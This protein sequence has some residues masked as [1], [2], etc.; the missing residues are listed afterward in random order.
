MNSVM[1]QIRELLARS[2]QMTRRF[3]ATIY[4]DPA[5]FFVF[6]A[7]VFG[8]V[9]IAFVPPFMNPD[10]DMHLER[11]YQI[12][13]GRLSAQNTDGIVGGEL[14]TSFVIAASSVATMKGDTNVKYS[15]R[16]AHLLLSMPLAKHKQELIDTRTAAPYV[17]IVYAPQVVGVFFGRLL[18][19]NPTFLLYIARFCGLIFFIVCGFVAIRLLPMKKWLLTLLLCLPMSLASASSVTA[20]TVIA[21]TLV[22]SLAMI[23]AALKDPLFAKKR[24][25]LPVLLAASFTLALSK[26]TYVL[27]GFLPLLLV[28]NKRRV[29][30]STQKKVVVIVLALTAVCWVGWAVHVQQ[31]NIPGQTNPLAVGSHQMV[32]NIE[33][34]P[35]QFA[36][37]AGNSLVTFNA[38]YLFIEFVGMFGWEDTPLPIWMVIAFFT[39][40]T[41]FALQKEHVSFQLARRT[42]L[43]VAAAAVLTTAIVVSVVYVK[44]TLPVET[45]VDGLQG[46]YFWPIAVSLIVVLP[47]GYITFKTKGF[48][49]VYSVLIGLS[50]VVIL[51]RFYLLPSPF[52]H[53]MVSP[54]RYLQI[55]QTK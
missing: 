10:E 15:L 21:G 5:H 9:A 55:V 43:V 14:P 52:R 7:L 45:Y 3:L 24:Y 26:Q 16:T 44:W 36:G 25:F 4:T 30:S 40:L 31:L 23:V 34:N 6:H 49:V 28:F 37:I 1:A 33:S 41:L 48:A 20:D 46:R 47:A 13:T 39:L 29:L 17:P 53:Q 12:S 38:N 35:V 54:G 32:K 18:D 2:W 11:I 42:K 8:I 19:L 22:V 50:M 27:L 51:Y